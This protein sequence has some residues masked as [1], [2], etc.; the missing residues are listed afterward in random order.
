VSAYGTSAGYISGNKN[1]PG[2]GEKAPYIHDFGSLLGFIEQVFNLNTANY[3][4]GIG[5]PHFPYADWFA[6]DG[7]NAGCSQT[8]CPYPLWDFF[9]FNNAP[10]TFVPII[11]WKYPANCFHT[12]ATASCFGTTY[13]PSDPDDDGIHQQD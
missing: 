7:H 11:S 2:G 13:Q 9:N 1:L 12:P 8:T 6:P 3:P 5:D 10:S 4:S